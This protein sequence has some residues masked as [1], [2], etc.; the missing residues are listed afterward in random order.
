MSVV[1]FIPVLVHFT[2]QEP[3]KKIHELFLMDKKE[4]L[5]SEKGIQSKKKKACMFV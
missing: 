4:T 3:R 1:T 2:N 5:Y